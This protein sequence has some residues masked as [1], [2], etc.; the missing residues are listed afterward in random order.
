[1]AFENYSLPLRGKTLAISPDGGVRSHK[2]IHMK[3]LVVNIL[4]C[5]SI[6]SV[7]A[8]EL[9]PIEKIQRKFVSR[10]YETLEMM[11]ERCP[12]SVKSEYLNS[13]KTFEKAYPEFV[14]LVNRSK[15]REY[16]ITKF[17]NKSSISENECRYLK[18]ALDA[19]VTS[20]EGIKDMNKNTET[21][22]DSVKNK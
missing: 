7:G 13:V 4:F 14:S 12:E 11:P 20:E 16:A 2:G 10:F 6:A 18:G 8:T 5:L 1:M 19:W 3:Y 9:S 22:S 21:M 17:S 15:F